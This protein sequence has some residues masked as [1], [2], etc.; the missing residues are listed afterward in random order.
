MQMIICSAE[1]VKHLLSHVINSAYSRRILI[2]VIAHITFVRL[3]LQ[4]E[5]VNF[6]SGLITNTGH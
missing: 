1:L 3:L 6:H 5:K 2:K 4:P